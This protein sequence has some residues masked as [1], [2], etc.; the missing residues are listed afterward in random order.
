[1]V[2]VLSQ[3]YPLGCACCLKSPLREDKLGSLGLMFHPHEDSLEGRHTFAGI[4]HLPHIM[5][6]NILGYRTG[7]HYCAQLAYVNRIKGE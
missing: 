2:P 4:S 5:A 1:M 7:S 3:I 6:E